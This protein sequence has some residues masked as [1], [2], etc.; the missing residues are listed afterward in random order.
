MSAKLFT[1]QTIGTCSLGNTGHE[2]DKS[3][4]KKQINDLR[5]SQFDISSKYSDSEGSV[6]GLGDK[7]SMKHFRMLH[8]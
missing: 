5:V 1:T 7:I 4:D 3:D 8:S 6:A 2:T